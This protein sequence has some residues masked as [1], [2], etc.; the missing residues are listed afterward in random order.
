MDPKQLLDELNLFLEGAV[1]QIGRAQRSSHGEEVGIDRFA[2]RIDAVFA[3]VVAL[4]NDVRERLMTV[5]ATT[6][7]GPRKL[8]VI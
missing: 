6:P 2:E 1:D 8:P 4:R 3:D 7:K 5:L